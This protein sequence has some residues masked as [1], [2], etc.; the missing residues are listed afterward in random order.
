MADASTPGTAPPRSLPPRR[1][2]ARAAGYEQLEELPT[3]MLLM[4]NFQSAACAADAA[5][6]RDTFAALAA[7]LL[8][9]PR[10]QARASGAPPRPACC[11]CAAGQ[12]VAG[13]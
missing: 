7:T 1:P 2:A 8:R 10:L 13:A 11:A 4:G 5:A 12:T 9:F 3:L 6:A